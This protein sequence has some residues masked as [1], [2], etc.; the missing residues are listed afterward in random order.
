MYVVP[1]FS[2]SRKYFSIRKGGGNCRTLTKP[3]KM[4][5]SIGSHRNHPAKDMVIVLLISTLETTKKYFR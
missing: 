5:K 1:S 3:T 2:F 4:G